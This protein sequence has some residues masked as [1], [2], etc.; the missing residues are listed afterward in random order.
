LIRVIREREA[1][2]I[3]MSWQNLSL[4]WKMSLPIV[5]VTLLLLILS[6]QQYKSSK[7]VTNDFVSIYEN[8]VPA[9][10]LTLN[11]DRDLYQAQVAERSL[12]MGSS[13]KDYMKSYKENVQQVDDRLSKVLELEINSKIKTEV[14]Q[15][16]KELRSWNSASLSMLKN[17]ESGKLSVVKASSMSEG[18]L[19]NRF[20]SIRDIL[21][22]IGEDLSS[23]STSLAEEVHETSKNAISS[24]LLICIVAII[25]SISVSV[26]FPKLILAPIHNLHA[27]IKGIVDG[28]GDLTT[29]LPELGKDEIGCLSQSFN[30]FLTSM[31]SLVKN[32]LD[33]S[34]QV[35]TCSNDVGKIVVNNNKSIQE[36]ASSIELVSAAVN[37]MGTAISDVSQNTQQVASEAS[38]ADVEAKKARD[39]F[40]G[41]INDINSLSD[42]VDSSASVVKELEGE[43]T[44]IASVLDVIQGI[45]E[46]TNLLALNAAIEAARAGE[47]GRGFA[48]VA[49]EVRT[50]ASKT[51][52]STTHINEM[53]EKLQKG[54]VKAVASMD[55]VKSKAIV[56]VE[57]A[58]NASHSIDGVTNYL[59]SISGNVIQV[60]AAVEEQA[61]VVEDINKNISQ[62]NSLSEGL[63]AGADI[64]ANAESNLKIESKQL[65]EQVANFKV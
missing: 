39:I 59:N 37:E 11:A 32:I 60:A 52:E 44:S 62:I 23:S 1:W 29:R 49:D 7:I 6:F 41:T 8:Y 13:N 43:A 42:N 3:D 12:A 36:L 38:E 24:M 17:L 64:V 25:I 61:T 14:T 4:K 58:G 33:S 63:A 2:G 9:L 28:E 46:Q 34:I 50:L 57:S 45:A 5:I 18:E 15:F 19:A 26:I 55:S 30:D 53:I 35:D 56:T 51:Q 20:E 54:V 31:Q 10:D 16:L 27:A 65:K 21:D 47:Q 48:V 40:S 22:K